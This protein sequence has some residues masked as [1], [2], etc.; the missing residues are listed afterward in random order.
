MNLNVDAV[1]VMHYKPLVER[2]THIQDLMSSHNIEYTVFD[3]E[4]GEKLD[5]Y[6]FDD[7]DTRKN[8][9]LD[10]QMKWYT[11]RTQHAPRRVS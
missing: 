10:K 5:E 2:L 11:D 9:L 7:Y 1:Y 4:P 3:E 8:K 6:F